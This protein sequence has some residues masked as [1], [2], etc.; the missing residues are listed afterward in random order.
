MSKDYKA[1]IL[2]AGMGIR[3]GVLS[4]KIP[5]NMLQIKNRSIL[6]NQITQ[7]YNC[8][9]RSI[10]IVIG[11]KKEVIKEFINGILSNY[12]GLSIN[13]IENKIYDQTS[14]IYS[15]WLTKDI[16]RNNHALYLNGDCFFEFNVLKQIMDSN[17]ESCTAIIKNQYNEEQV[18]VTINSNN[19]IMEIS[20]TIQPAKTDGEFVGVTKMSHAF[21]QKLVM[22]L[23]ELIEKENQ[24]KKFA[25]DS[26]NLSIQ[27]YQ[28]EIY[29]EF[30]DNYQVIEID[31][32]Q[33]YE[34]AKKF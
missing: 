8:G 33:D 14:A 3:M 26:F 32:K 18:K 30:V 6:H 21:N 10:Y 34:Q 4:E 13:F 2:A 23:D 9:I 5:K 15:L 29:A 22:A 19:R 24:I 11:Y 7:L 27:K 12:P 1:I 31:T 16:L 28:N 25:I 20:K 17:Y